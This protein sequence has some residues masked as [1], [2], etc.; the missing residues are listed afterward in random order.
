MTFGLIL[1]FLGCGVVAT[2]IGGSLP[3]SRRGQIIGAVVG[4]A[5]F[6]AFGTASAV[7]LPDV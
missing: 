4:G 7:F 2:F 1:A 6:L 3:T 5:V